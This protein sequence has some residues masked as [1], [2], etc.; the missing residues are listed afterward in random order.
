[1]N[2]FEYFNYLKT[3]SPLGRAYRRIL[4]YPN[5]V[6]YSSGRTIDIGCGLGSLLSYNPEIIGVDIN[7]HCVEYC[8]NLGLKAFT[9]PVNILPFDNGSFET[10]ILDNVLEHI[11]EPA[12]LIQE[13][14]RV[15]VRDGRVIIL[16]PGIKGFHKD[17][18]HKKYYD[19]RSLKTFASDNGF[20]VL[21]SKGLPFP[22]LSKL[23]SGFCY[24]VV[25]KKFN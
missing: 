1:M 20:S 21:K 15:L 16:V 10:V 23:F 6:K 22:G 7:K 24:F 12:T 5:I 18:D 13:I 25:F 4:V 3:I 14:K 17:P 2:A 9:M 8:Q 19:A 11:A